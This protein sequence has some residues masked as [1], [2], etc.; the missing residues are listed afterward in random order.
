MTKEQK[1]ALARI[2]RRQAK[3]FAELPALTSLLDTYAAQK[4]QVPKDWRNDL[5]HLQK[6]A[7]YQQVLQEFEPTISRLESSAD[8]T[9]LIELFE[10]MSHG[11]LPN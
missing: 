11:K 1:K 3:M 2:F 7:V 5:G 6:S 9:D 4:M 8:D 10:K